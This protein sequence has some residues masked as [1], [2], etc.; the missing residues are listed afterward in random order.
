M[1]KVLV[2]EDDRLA[3]RGL[4]NTMP[5]E[6]CNMTVVGEA[7]NGK[8]ALD[9]LAG[10]EVDLVLS[11]YSMP[12]MS[13]LDLAKAM[14]EKYPRVMIALVTMYESFDIIQQA[15]RLGV[16]DYISKLQLEDE[17]CE[18]V[19]ENLSILIR[20][21]RESEGRRESLLCED[22]VCFG[23]F[24]PDNRDIEELY[25]RY[26]NIFTSKPHEIE[27]GLYVYFSGASAWEG[28]FNEPSWVLIQIT[29]LRGQNREA[30]FH[31]LRS[32]YNGNAFYQRQFTKLSYGELAQ[33]EN[34]AAAGPANAEELIGKE[35]LGFEWLYD[36]H[37]FE[38]MLAELY[39]ARLPYTSLFKMLVHLETAW[40]QN[41]RVVFPGISF[42][43]PPE[44][45]SWEAV[46]SWLREFFNGVSAMMKNAQF[47]AE[48]LGGV[49][50]SIGIIYNELDTQL[51]A[52]DVARRVNFSR[53]YFSVCFKKITGMSFNHFLR[54]ARIG[55]A[56]NY[57]K[58]S[59]MS[60]QF[61]AEKTGYL[62]EKYFC[63]IFKKETG[64]LP[65]QYRRE[66]KPGQGG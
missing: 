28:V 45:S 53:S 11:D 50:K 36:E 55:Q 29:G 49:T 40:E 57:L 10:N 14:N 20:K 24:S 30:F 35:W 16:L 65:T 1:I 25:R 26:G 37:G 21:R 42:R 7:S 63:R 47:S 13:G 17:S 4:I 33:Q 43:L 46:E 56:K 27:N 19:L 8:A 34:G 9:F 62:D 61:V 2:V 12:V 51:F 64:I 31:L 58:N 32:Y 60:V 39:A 5:W 44:F 54:M 38:K 3:R 22:D 52:D 66:H 48:I 23:F 41:Y 6:K 18:G 59:D 15:L